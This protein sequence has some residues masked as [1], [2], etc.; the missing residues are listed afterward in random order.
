METSSYSTTK[1]E[2]PV[3]EYPK[4]APTLWNP[5]IAGVWS[6]FF[7]PIFGSILVLKNW[8]AIGDEG[9]VKAAKIWLLVS[10]LMLIPVA[11]IPLLALIYLITW[12]FAW[13]RNQTKFIKEQWGK[14]YPRK[15]W[16]VPLLLGI[17]SVVFYSIIYI[18]LKT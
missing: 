14:D 8:Q 11:F 3:E 17:V 1:S 6:V 18:F 9:R 16:G 2:L 10:I 12:Y 13:Q 7:T 5:D 15:S 4:V